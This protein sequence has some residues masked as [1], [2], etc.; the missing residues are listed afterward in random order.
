MDFMVT[1]EY[2][3]PEVFAPVFEFESAFVFVPVFEFESVFAFVFV[4][5]SLSASPGV[6]GRLWES[7][8]DSD[9]G[10]HWFCW[11]RR[12]PGGDKN[13]QKKLK[14]ETENQKQS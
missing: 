11:E 2:V 10:R 14:T 4:P 5:V 1:N 3:W 8:P 6:L 9:N 7:G 12:H 13:K